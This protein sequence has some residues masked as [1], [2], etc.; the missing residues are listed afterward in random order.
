MDVLI[1]AC[2]WNGARVAGWPAA[3][4]AGLMIAS[5]EEDKGDTR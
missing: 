4:G 5:G 2:G 1:E 3:D